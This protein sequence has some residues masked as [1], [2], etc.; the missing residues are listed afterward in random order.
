MRIITLLIVAGTIGAI[1]T[2]QARAELT[3]E[4]VLNLY[5]DIDKGPASLQ[6]LSL[7]QIASLHFQTANHPVASL[8][9]LKKY[10]K[11]ED[12]SEQIGFCF[13]RAMAAYLIARKMGLAPASI[14]KLFIVGDLRSGKDPEWRFHVTTVVRGSDARWYAIDP[15][16]QPIPVLQ[17]IKKVQGTWDKKHQA[18]LY[19]TSGSVV[20]PDL[21]QVPAVETGERLIEIAF[22]PLKV[23]GFSLSKLVQGAFAATRSTEAAY[24]TDVYEK[25]EADRFNF[26]SVRVNDHEFVY[27]GYF[28]DLLSD[29]HAHDG[30][31]GQI[32][33][34]QEASPL[35]VPY[36]V[37]LK[38]DNLYSPR[39]I[40]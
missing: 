18:R 28:S 32:K 19:L 11:S 5:Q 16:F 14:R 33:P 31:D 25:N 35:S 34:Q 30:T 36:S 21:S 26:L 8:A 13:G 7:K 6:A 40:R 12:P 3:S 10:D 38:K 15:L 22:D 17:W 27:N 2:L 29:L 1:T 37:R 9:N 4:Q 20:I 23:K 39:F 24:F